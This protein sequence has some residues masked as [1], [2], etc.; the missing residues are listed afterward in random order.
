MN[1]VQNDLP[2]GASVRDLGEHR[3]KD[4]VSPEHLH[5]LEIEGVASDFPPPRTLDARPNNLPPQLTSFVGREHDLAALRADL[6]AH[7]LVTLLGPGG[8][9]KTRLS[10]EGAESAAAAL[11]DA[12]PHGVWLAELAPVDDPRTVVQIAVHN[13]GRPAATQFRWR[14][15][16]RR[17]P[18]VGAGHLQELYELERVRDVP[19]ELLRRATDSRR[20][21]GGALWV[22]PVLDGFQH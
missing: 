16:R 15:Q 9:G 6:A 12:W 1:L 17:L 3:L 11:P 21:N 14:S 8:A 18:R 7:R 5:D 22:Q 13:L 4:L 20:P 19:P 10:Q 2:R